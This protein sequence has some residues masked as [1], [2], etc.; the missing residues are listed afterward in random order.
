VLDA[1]RALASGPTASYFEVTRPL[2]L[3][4]D[5]L[6][7]GFPAGSQFNRRNADKPE[8]RSQLVAALKSVTGEEFT[9][10]YTELGSTAGA[11]EAPAEAPV[12]DEEQFVERVKS[13]FN[14]EEVI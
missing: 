3:E 10:E 14:A 8:Q 1:L 4:G 6:T 9:L 13:E 2:G 11:E 12:V 7:I 5:R